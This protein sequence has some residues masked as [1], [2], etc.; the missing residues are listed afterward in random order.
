MSFA[1]YF[2]PR[3]LQYGSEVPR[4]FGAIQTCAWYNLGDGA[5]EEWLI[6]VICNSLGGAR[7]IVTLSLGIRGGVG[8]MFKG[9]ILLIQI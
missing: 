7:K 3:V 6:A 9:W 4:E 2:G 8:E 5:E 1:A